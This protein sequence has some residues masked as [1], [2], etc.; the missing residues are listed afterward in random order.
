MFRNDKDGVRQSCWGIPSWNQW[1]VAER[2]RAYIP[3]PIVF[4]FLL[5]QHHPSPD[6]DVTGGASRED[7]RCAVS[8]LERMTCG[9]LQLAIVLVLVNLW[10][11][12]HVAQIRGT[13]V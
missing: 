11:T 1:F 6:N 7:A 3:R 13:A 9:F 10:F 8:G 2:A 5:L 4:F 12:L